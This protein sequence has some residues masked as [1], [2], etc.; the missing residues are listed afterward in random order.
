MG[1]IFYVSCAEDFFEQLKVQCVLAVINY[2]RHFL[3]AVQREAVWKEL[4]LFLRRHEHAVGSGHERSDTAPLHRRA[5][6]ADTSGGLAVFQQSVGLLL[7]VHTKVQ[8]YPVF[9]DRIRHSVEEPCGQRVGV[10]PYADA[11]RSFGGVKLRLNV[12]FQQFHLIIVGYERLPCLCRA[13][14][15]RPHQ[16]NGHRLLF[17]LF[18]PLRYGGLGYA[19]LIRRLF[20]T[21]GLHNAGKSLQKFVIVHNSPPDNI[22]ITY[23]S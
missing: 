14:W 19:E 11:D 8:E 12:A 21:A 9:H 13:G 15:V 20:K 22:S 10:K 2:Q 5:S 23:V 6:G 16:K 18:Y 1:V 17:Q 3:Y 4:P 7:I